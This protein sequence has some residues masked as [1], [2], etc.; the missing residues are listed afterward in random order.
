MI[1]DTDIALSVLFSQELL[2]DDAKRKA[3]VKVIRD[4]VTPK[5]LNTSGSREAKWKWPHVQQA[6]FDS[7]HI[8]TLK[9]KNEFGR[10]MSPITGC[11]ASSISQTFKR[12]EKK[13]TDVNIILA[14]R[15]LI[16][17]AI[18]KAQE[19]N[20]D[21]AVGSVIP[22]RKDVKISELPFPLTSL[23]SI[24]RT[25]ASIAGHI[26]SLEPYFCPD[27]T[28]E[29]LIDGFEDFAKKF[30]SLLV[31]FDPKRENHVLCHIVYRLWNVAFIRGDVPALEEAIQL[32]KSLD[33]KISAEKLCEK[34]TGCL[35]EH[36][37]EDVMLFYNLFEHNFRLFMQSK[38]LN[39]EMKHY[40]EDVIGGAHEE[41]V[42][43]VEEKERARYIE[44][45]EMTLRTKEFFNPYVSEAMIYEFY[46]AMHREL[47]NVVSLVRLVD[48]KHLDR[49]VAKI[50]GELLNLNI[51]KPNTSRSKLAR[52]IS[53]NSS[54][55]LLVKNMHDGTKDEKLNSWIR[56]FW[57]DMQNMMP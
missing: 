39:T 36:L 43:V 26:L 12:F 25:L 55:K 1:N 31:H 51:Y 28:K 22:R 37:P 13:E 52:I 27:C 21:N 34:L 33:G 9:N 41:Y 53:K 2:N 15:K 17:G 20:A 7:K 16:D 57:S 45:I 35:Y 50:V 29:I 24:N 38:G 42:E 40:E 8:V 47:S 4:E 3:F 44:M 30:E 32:S 54:A 48:P 14:I 19:T 23:A 18:A 10:S 49:G 46:L 11:T 6:L 56:M 5:V